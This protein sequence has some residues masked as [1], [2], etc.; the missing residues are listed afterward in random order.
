MQHSKFES[1][2]LICGRINVTPRKCLGYRVL[3][4]LTVAR[5]MAR[6][7]SAPEAHKSS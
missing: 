4:E 2:G 6:R 3:A 1:K 5:A 7:T